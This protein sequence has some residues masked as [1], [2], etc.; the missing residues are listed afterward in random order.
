MMLVGIHLM[1]RSSAK[2]STA[3]VKKS[4]TAGCAMNGTMGA[5]RQCVTPGAYEPG[6]PTLRHLCIT[7]GPQRRR[8]RLFRAASI[9]LR[10]P[11][12]F[13]ALDLRV[14]RLGCLEIF[15]A[16]AVLVLVVV[17]VLERELLRRKRRH[18]LV[19]IGPEQT[20]E[21]AGLGHPVQLLAP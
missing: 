13:L 6:R 10:D 20:C 19:L 5:A 8:G 1:K 12:L 7:V 11:R 21:R 3:L 17:Q 9:C 18:R 14:G 16:L 15:E 2:R 4:R